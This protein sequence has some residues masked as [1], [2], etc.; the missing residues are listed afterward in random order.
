MSDPLLALVL[1][2]CVLLLVGVGLAGIVLPA[3]PGVPM[4]F[5][6]LWLA[7]WIDDYQ[8]VGAFTLVL[9]GLLVLLSLA[10]DFLA[11]AFGAR[12]VGAH[13]RALTGAAL[14]TLIGLFFGLPGLLLGPFAGALLG[15]FSVRGDVA[16]ATRAGVATWIGL[17]FGALAKVALAFTMIGVFV[18]AYFL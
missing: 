1:W 5:I 10:I 9:L 16:Q 14:G 4:I 11:G 15:E 13:P 7:A 3:L 17:L 18:L 6:G 2:G 8:R 12:R